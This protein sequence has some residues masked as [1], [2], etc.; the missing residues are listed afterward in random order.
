MEPETRNNWNQKQNLQTQIKH[1]EIEDLLDRY[2]IEIDSAIIK[3]DLEDK[4]ILVTGGAGSIGSEIVRQ[5]ALFNPRKIRF[6]QGH[7]IS[8]VSSVCIQMT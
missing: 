4:T 5:L 3:N 7:E 1:I 6:F 8:S 2:P